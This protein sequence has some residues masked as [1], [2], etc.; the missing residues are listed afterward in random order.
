MKSESARIAPILEELAHATDRLSAIDR[1]MTELK[2]YLSLTFRTP[3]LEHDGAL[4]LA[5]LINTALGVLF[6][7]MRDVTAVCEVMAKNQDPDVHAKH[8]YTELL[9]A[10]I[11]L[12]RG[13]VR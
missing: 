13:M 6:Y 11:V 1:T 9:R 12:R 4:F 3:P 2:R 7:L 5:R 10:L 8:K